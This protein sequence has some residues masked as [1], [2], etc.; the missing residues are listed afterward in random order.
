MK[1]S[2]NSI[3]FTA[4]SSEGKAFK[5]I[6]S[7]LYKFYLEKPRPLNIL[8]IKIDLVDFFFHTH[9]NNLYCSINTALI[10]S[11]KYMDKYCLLRLI[12]LASTILIIKKTKYQTVSLAYF[13]P[14]CWDSWIAIKELNHRSWSCEFARTWR[15][16][17]LEP[18]KWF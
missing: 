7:L 5:S 10:I 6:A 8:T 17:Q 12:K 11:W 15:K 16:L 14:F 2:K 3:C 4:Y 1:Y 13:Y 9:A 18:N